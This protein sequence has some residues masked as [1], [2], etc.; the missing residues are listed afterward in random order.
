MEIQIK[1]IPS[2]ALSSWICS[3]E[4]LLGK[5]NLEAEREY[6][7]GT[8]HNWLIL[9]LSSFK[10]F[11]IPNQTLIF[12]LSDEIVL[13]IPVR[14]KCIAAFH[15]ENKENRGIYSLLYD[16]KLPAGEKYLKLSATASKQKEKKKNGAPTSADDFIGF[17]E[18]KQERI[19]LS[20]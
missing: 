1:L 17:A 9:C 3:K 2:K 7:F 5:N 10:D 11:L 18:S 19:P 4:I 13:K 20:N 14:A 6:T 16:K 12:W 15:S 8:Q